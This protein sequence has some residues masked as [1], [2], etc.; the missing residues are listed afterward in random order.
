MVDQQLWECCKYADIV[1]SILM[2]FFSFT[3]ACDLSVK[4]SGKVESKALFILK[5]KTGDQFLQ[6]VTTCFKYY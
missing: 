5:E 2:A 3:A 4:A 6:K 1:F